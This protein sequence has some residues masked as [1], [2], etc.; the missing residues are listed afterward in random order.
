ML[1]LKRDTF[2]EKSTIGTLVLD[3]E[4]L[5][6]TLEDP[7]REG[8]DG[9]LDQGEKIPGETAIPRGTY[10]VIINISTRFKREM[11][12]LLHV[13]F[14]TGVR[15]HNGNTAAHTDGCIL[16]GLRTS[17][18]DFIANSIHTFDTIVMPKLR[19][20]IDKGPLYIYVRN[21]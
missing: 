21:V 12:L 1:E 16:V 8:S 5:C 20:R 10:Q 19:E 3:D 2:T 18:P 6:D 13:P 7:V 9:I 15:I 11:P 14:F 4:F 17:T